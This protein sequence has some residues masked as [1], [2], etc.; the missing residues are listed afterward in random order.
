MFDK[1]QIRI[2]KL[3]RYQ[4]FLLKKKWNDKF[5]TD[6]CLNNNIYFN[7][8]KWIYIYIYIYIICPNDYGKIIF[9]KQSI[10]FVI[11]KPHLLNIGYI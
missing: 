6:T 7:I 2:Y 8:K 10:I 4:F 3:I 9:K 5:Y 1:K 11:N